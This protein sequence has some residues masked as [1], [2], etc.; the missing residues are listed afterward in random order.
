MSVISEPPTSAGTDFSGSGVVFQP[1]ERRR[2][3]DIQRQ[4]RGLLAI[5]R[6]M[7]R[8]MADSAGSV[9]EFAAHLEGR[10]GALA[11]VQGFLSR[12]PDAPV[13]LE[14]LARGEFL[15]QSITDEHFDIKGPRTL[16]AAKEAGTLGLALHE[17]ATNS[18]KFG[19]LARAD[20][21]VEVEWTR[22]GHSPEHATLEWREQTRQVVCAA[23][24]KGF[25]FELIEQTLPYELG[26]TSSI[27]LTPAGLRC[28][29]TFVLPPH[30]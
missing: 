9:E 17:L 29:I 20:G 12:A 18:I 14:D 3:F 8:R 19:A 27:V 6:S 10:L 1:D 11:R 7:V 15:A 26:G 30:E 16:L 24:H 5:V 23:T 21:R 22:S 25:G 13:D 2:F 4:V 28:S